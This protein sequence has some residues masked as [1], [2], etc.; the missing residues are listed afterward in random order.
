MWVLPQPYLPQPYLPPSHCITL[1]KADKSNQSAVPKVH[2]RLRFHLVS[3]FCY[4]PKDIN[5]R[6]RAH[7]RQNPTRSLCLT[8]LAASPLAE[9]S[10]SLSGNGWFLPYFA[11]LLEL[12]PG[13]FTWLSFISTHIHSN[14]VVVAFDEL[15]E[16]WSSFPYVTLTSLPKGS[17]P[18]LLALISFLSSCTPGVLRAIFLS[19]DHLS[20][21]WTWFSGFTIIISPSI[22]FF[23]SPFI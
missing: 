3:T 16:R 20:S 17:F 5:H 23:F 9:I 7:Q 14:T 11:P 4:T 2:P 15:P 8:A 21:I 19:E 10:S 6:A 18:L 22:P 13:L 1:H 12:T